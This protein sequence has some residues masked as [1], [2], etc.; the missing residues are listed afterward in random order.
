[1]N[2]SDLERIHGISI[3][4]T[5]FSELQFNWLAIVPKMS[6]IYN[7]RDEPITTKN[8]DIMVKYLEISGI[9]HLI[10]TVSRNAA[11]DLS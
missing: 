7:E 3:I 9:E 10:S 11:V 6:I 4:Q 2:N 1:M 8:N 5:L